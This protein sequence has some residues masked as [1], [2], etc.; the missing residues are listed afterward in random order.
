MTLWEND[1]VQFARLLAEIVATQ[2]KLDIDALC[3]SMDLT[4]DDIDEL[5]ERAQMCWEAYKTAPPA[6]APLS[7]ARYRVREGNV[8]VFLEIPEPDFVPEPRGVYHVSVEVDLPTRLMQCGIWRNDDDEHP[9]AQCSY[10]I[11]DY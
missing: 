8:T 4:P 5:F 11:E 2:E 10:E 3:T 7:Y 1:H 6:L 9:V